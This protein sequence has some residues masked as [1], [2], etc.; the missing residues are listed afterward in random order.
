MSVVDAA[1]SCCPVCRPIDCRA[2]GCADPKRPAGNRLETPP[3][4]CCSVCVAGPSEACNKGQ[5][6]YQSLREQLIQKYN[7]SPCKLD[8]DCT[9]V[10]EQ[11]ACV[12]DCGTAIFAAA[13]L[14]FESNSKSAS[15]DCASCPSPAIPPC[16]A[17]VA[18][19]SNGQCGTGSP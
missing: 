3:G 18:L 1:M 4:T 11:N 8:S 12:S 17:L 9:L 13:A 10:V 7:F 14:D 5:Q 2:V 6:S 15:V 16:A 19:R